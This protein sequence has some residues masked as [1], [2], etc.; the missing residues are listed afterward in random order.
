MHRTRTLIVGSQGQS[1]ISK[2]FQFIFN[3]AGAN[4]DTNLRFKESFRCIACAFRQNISCLHE[5]FIISTADHVCVIAALR[6]RYR[7]DNFFI[8]I[9]FICIFHEAVNHG[10]RF[11]FAHI[12]VDMANIGRKSLSIVLIFF[13]DCSSTS[14]HSSFNFRKLLRCK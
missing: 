12:S 1:G 9:I 5:A 11:L 2:L 10:V 7:H 4:F 14:R 13:S 3:I 8:Y 6:L